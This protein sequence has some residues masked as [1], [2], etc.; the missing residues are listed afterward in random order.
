MIN[1]ALFPVAIVALNLPA[2]AVFGLTLFKLTHNRIRNLFLLTLFSGIV[3]LNALL[4][5]W[6]IYLR[7]EWALP[8]AKIIF[9]AGILLLPAF[10]GFIRTLS[11]QA[12]RDSIL[13]AFYASSLIVLG[14]ILGGLVVSGVELNET[15]VS[16]LH[17]GTL[18]LYFVIH[19]ILFGAYIFFRLWQLSRK[20]DDA[21]IR[22]QLGEVFTAG[23]IT[24]ALIAVTNTIV[25]I[26]AGKTTAVL[27]GPVFPVVFLARIYALLTRGSRYFLTKQFEGLI[28][29]NT[30]S[31][32]EKNLL[33]WSEFLAFLGRSFESSASEMNRRLSFSGTAGTFDLLVSKRE[34]PLPSEAM[35]AAQVLGKQFSAGIIDQS[36]S[37]DRD[38]KRL[39]FALLRA[40]DILKQKLIPELENHFENR[41]LPAG[42]IL[43][44]ERITQTL[45]ENRAEMEAMTGI[46][47]Y[48]FSKNFAETVN[49][50]MNFARAGEPML[51]YGDKSTGRSLL[52]RIA[53]KTAGGGHP[54]ELFPEHEEIFPREV[55]RLLAT[56]GDLSVIV[57]NL[58]VLRPDQIELVEKLTHSRLRK[59]SL[60]MTASRDFYGSGLDL[61]DNLKRALSFAVSVPALKDREADVFHLALSF[62][63]EHR[64]LY[65]EVPFTA[66]HADYL[67]AQLAEAEHIHI[68]DIR[69]HVLQ[70]CLAAAPPVLAAGSEKSREVKALAA[71]TF[72][73][74]EES[75]RTVIRTFLLKNKLN[76]RRTAMELD[77]TINTLVA[78]ISRYKLSYLFGK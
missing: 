39:F 14:L 70:L 61:P 16:R 73:A 55:A 57:H 17:Y 51:F 29:K 66:V 26:F 62:I 15:G 45:D 48:C 34:K 13:Y 31:S 69:T 71:N 8:T 37:L 43:T 32:L 19:F 52:A 59:V 56:E 21:I 10:A 30:D 38:N 6:S 58:S 27:L 74:L 9:I 78:K 63:A 28:A 2:L 23:W 11:G 46:G 3:W 18:R 42:E 20:S 75:E 72:S 22:Y 1:E 64:N 12:G 7:A 68:A 36:I 49:H 47:F 33:S 50:T 35:P 54:A 5:F 53:A 24:F 40:Q 25:P 65:P 77:I 76:K 41:R 44:L 60:Y 4:Y 67:K